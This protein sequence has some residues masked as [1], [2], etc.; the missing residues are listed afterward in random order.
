MTGRWKNLAARAFRR[1][2]GT[3]NG[4]AA[5]FSKQLSRMRKEVEDLQEDC[6]AGVLHDGV[7]T[8]VEDILHRLAELQA[9]AR[10]AGL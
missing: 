2:F 4:P 5:N 1:F 3:T 8:R 6:F 7:L 10:E 9:A